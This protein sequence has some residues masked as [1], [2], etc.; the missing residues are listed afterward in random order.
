MVKTFFH[1]CDSLRRIR[2][3][4]ISTMVKTFIQGELSVTK[5]CT[6]IKNYYCP[7]KTNHI[8]FIHLKVRINKA[9][10]IYYAKQAP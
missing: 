3:E 2:S 9:L 5:Q 10:E 8:I 4:N 7:I 6:A 1:Y